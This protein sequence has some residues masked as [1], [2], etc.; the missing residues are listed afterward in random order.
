MTITVDTSA[1]VAI[2][3]GEPDAEHYASIL[4]HNAGDILVSSATVIEASIVLL[5]KHGEPG[6]HD[7]TRLMDL[8]G[9]TTTPVDETIGRAAITAWR[10]FGKGRHPAGL[11]LG[12]CF[13][14]ALAKSSGTALLYKGDD[15]TQTDIASAG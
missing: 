10:R 1:L 9:V 13:S 6:E 5:A 4:N 3:L 12:D 14:Y 11:N 2:I 7:L 8:V 15:F